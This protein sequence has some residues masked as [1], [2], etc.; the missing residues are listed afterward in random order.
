MEYT[1]DKVE[2]K[3]GKIYTQ[4]DIY[5]RIWSAYMVKNTLTKIYSWQNKIYK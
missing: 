2:Y 3:Y 5:G 4:W 1:Y